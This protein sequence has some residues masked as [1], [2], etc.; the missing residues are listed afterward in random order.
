MG[1]TLHASPSCTHLYPYSEDLPGRSSVGHLL[2]SG[3]YGQLPFTYSLW[4]LGYP[5]LIAVV[6]GQLPL[7]AVL[8]FSAPRRLFLKVSSPELW[9]LGSPLPGCCCW[10]SAPL[11]C[12]SWVLR[13]PKAVARGQL[14]TEW[15]LDYLMGNPIANPAWVTQLQTL[16][17]TGETR[18][19]ADRI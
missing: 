16:N 12:G 14:H 6:K 4:C 13:S 17:R 3:C 10:G 7:S 15:F 11:N 9:Y 5:V 1:N 18:T 8:G 2:F 19:C